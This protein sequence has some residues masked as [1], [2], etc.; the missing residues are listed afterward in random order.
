M[1]PFRFRALVTLDQ[2]MRKS[3]RRPYPSGTRSLMVHARHSGQPSCD[4]Y[5]PATIAEENGLPIQP[6][7][8]TPVTVTVVDDEAPA[9]F[10]PGQV[11]TLWGASGGYGVVTRRVV[12]DFGP[13]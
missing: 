3:A 10:R 12:T 13:S 11:F 9:Y 5:F 2:P 8:R 1:K 7:R 4:R 6:G